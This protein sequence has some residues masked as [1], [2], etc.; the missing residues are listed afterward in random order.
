VDDISEKMVSDA[1]YTGPIPDPDIL[2][3][4]SGEMRISNF[5]LWQVSYS[6]LYFTNCCWPD[7]DEKAMIQALADYQ[8]RNRR[9]GLVSS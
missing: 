6:E 4:T 7:F 1:L 5:L 3:R 9:Y 8:K 2:I